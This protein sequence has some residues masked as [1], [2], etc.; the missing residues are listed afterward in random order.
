VTSTAPDPQAEALKNAAPI[1]APPSITAEASLRC[2]DNSLVYI[3]FYKGE[4]QVVVR[5]VKGGTG[6]TLTAPAAGQPYVADGYKVT[7]NAK[8][9][10]VALPGKSAQSC[11]A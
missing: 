5:T 9:A 1:V 8:A 7:G 11:H 2:A 6:T 10:S 3:D 4:T